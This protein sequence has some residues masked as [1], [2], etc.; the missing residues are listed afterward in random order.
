M[1]TPATTMAPDP[2]DLTRLLAQAVPRSVSAAL[3]GIEDRQA[4]RVELLEQVSRHGTPDVDY[5]DMPTF[6]ELPINFLDGVIE[7]DLRAQLNGYWPEGA[8][9]FAGLAYRIQPDTSKFEAVYLRPTNGTRAQAL[10]PR[11]QRAIQYFAYP[12]HRFEQLRTQHPGTYEAG[13]PIDI[14]EWIT[15]RLVIHDRHLEAMVDGEPALDV[16]PT[17]I[18]AA[19]GQIGLFVDIGTIA[20]FTNLRVTRPE[21]E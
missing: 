1:S 14:D 5:V 3:A 19:H 20:Y 21:P 13:A 7:V 11:N 2:L 18:P 16:S 17:L 6:L 9:G 12:D 8:R 10:S 4:I 15:L